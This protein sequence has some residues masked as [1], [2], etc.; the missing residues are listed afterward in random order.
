MAVS[1]FISGGQG[2]VAPTLG[3]T[4]ASSTFRGLRLRLRVR[5]NIL[6]RHGF[7]R[8]LELD[9]EPPQSVASTEDS[10]VKDGSRLSRQHGVSKVEVVF[11]EFVS[12]SGMKVARQGVIAACQQYSTVLSLRRERRHPNGPFQR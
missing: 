8:S 9:S 5:V 4:A 10:G 6:Y 7:A 11:T 2:L 1:S 3:F 12:F